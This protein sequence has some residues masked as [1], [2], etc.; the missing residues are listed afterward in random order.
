MEN[1]VLHR[2]HRSLWKRVNRQQLSLA[3]STHPILVIWRDEFGLIKQQIHRQRNSEHLQS[4]QRD[5]DRETSDFF[6]QAY[7]EVHRD[8]PWYF[9]EE[10]V[11]ENSQHAGQ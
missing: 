11:F 2:R 4:D 9:D 1:V 8:N 10:Q 6:K 3:L 5:T 7:R